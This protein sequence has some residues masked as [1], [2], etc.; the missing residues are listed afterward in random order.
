M[1][2][3]EHGVVKS[4]RAPTREFRQLAKATHWDHTSFGLGEREVGRGSPEA[5]S[6]GWSGQS[7]D[8][9]RLLEAARWKEHG[10]GV[11]PCEVLQGRSDVPVRTS[12]HH[13]VGRKV[14]VRD[15]VVSALQQLG[16]ARNC[17]RAPPT[18]LSRELQQW[19]DT[20]RDK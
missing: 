11:R 12:S 4:M 7:S 13:C 2:A 18:Q 16:A 14:G 15:P 3:T 19:L 10:Y 1:M 9:D 17:G 5:G 8:S 6:S 20:L